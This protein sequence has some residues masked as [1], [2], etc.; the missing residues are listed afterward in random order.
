MSALTSSS[1]ATL[2][3]IRHGETTWNAAGI[4][5][6]HLPSELSPLGHLQAQAVARRLARMPPFDAIYSSDLLRSLQTAD[7]LIALR[8]GTVIHE[9]RLRERSMGVFDGLTWEQ[10]QSRFPDEYADYKTGR[11][12][13]AMPEGESSQ[14]VYDRVITCINDLAARHAGRRILIFTHGGVLHRIFRYVTDSPRVGPRCFSLFNAAINS[15][16]H[17]YKGWSVE[18]WG[19]I[20]HLEAIGTQSDN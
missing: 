11:L 13:F 15:I 3:L 9:P 10:V 18:T 16:R 5:Q 7:Y 12:D 17:G 19:D 20:A 4:L 2:T 14:R 8:P 6:G 1:D